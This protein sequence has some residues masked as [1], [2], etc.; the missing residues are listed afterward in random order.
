LYRD[1]CGIF[2][3][4]EPNEEY[5]V[6]LFDG[7]ATYQTTFSAPNITKTYGTNIYLGKYLL[8]GTNANYSIL[9]SDKDIKPYFWLFNWIYI[10]F[11]GIAFVVSIFMFF[12]IPDK[13]SLSLVFGLGFITMLTLARIIIWFYW[14]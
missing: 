5:A 3:F 4:Y 14:G 1:G 7:V 13:P 9:F 12:V 10:I 6:R 2:K 8:N 11:I